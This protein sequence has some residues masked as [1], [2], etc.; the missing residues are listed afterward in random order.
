MV[1]L[2][3][4]VLRIDVVNKFLINIVIGI[5]IFVLFLNWGGRVKFR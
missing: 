4:I 3:G 1:F 5:I 2:V